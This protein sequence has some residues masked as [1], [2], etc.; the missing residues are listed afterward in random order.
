MGDA[1][2]VHVLPTLYFIDRS[3]KVHEAHS[4]YADEAE[5]RS[6]IE[7]ALKGGT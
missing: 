2:N 7:D 3:G 6:L 1:Y 5:L 4:G